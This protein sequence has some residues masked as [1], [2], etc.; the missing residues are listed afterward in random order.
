MNLETEVSDIKAQL[1][2]SIERINETERRTSHMEDNVRRIEFQNKQL[3]NENIDLKETLL[4]MQTRSMRD[5]LI[6]SNFPETNENE[7]PGETED[8][9]KKFISEK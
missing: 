1:A 4:D 3:Y 2:Y 7:T 6:F 5:N 9:V 8:V